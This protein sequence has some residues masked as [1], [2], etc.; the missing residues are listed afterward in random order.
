MRERERKLTQEEGDFLNLL[1]REWV[2]RTSTLTISRQDN[3]DKRLLLRQQQGR[4]SFK[5]YMNKCIPAVD[6]LNERETV[7]DERFVE[8]GSYFLHLFF[9][10][11]R[12]NIRI[13]ASSNKNIEMPRDARRA[14]TSH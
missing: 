3:E 8:R 7:K 9:E 5:I 10:R 13:T 11:Q 1:Q 12:L 14:V 4:C 2:S 6:Q